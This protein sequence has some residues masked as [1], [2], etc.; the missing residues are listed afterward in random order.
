M[1]LSERI[2]EAIQSAVV[3][4]DGSWERGNPFE[5]LVSMG[6]SVDRLSIVNYKL[7]NLKDEVMRRPEDTSFRAWAS[8]EDVKLVMERSRLKRCID[9]K[10]IAMIGK[11]S[12]GDK[13]AGFNPEV[14][15]Y[16]ADYGNES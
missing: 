2:D 16:G 15:K 14:K 9:E 1:T 12:S 4:Y 6:E 5:E 13:A 8:E 7:Y 11:F 3:S 10:M